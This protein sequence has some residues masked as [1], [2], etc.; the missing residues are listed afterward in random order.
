ME[1]L[2]RG[3]WRWTLVKPT[4]DMKENIAY[5]EHIDGH[6]VQLHKDGQFIVDGKE[7]GKWED[8]R[9]KKPWIPVKRKNFMSLAKQ[10]LRE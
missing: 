9:T 10:Y 7:S 2:N 8:T 1:N 5:D 4:S 6:H 3:E